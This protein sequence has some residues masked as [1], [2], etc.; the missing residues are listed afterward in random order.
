MALKDFDWK[1]LIAIGF[2]AGLIQV[3]FGV[4]MY[5]LGI[6]F[7][8][9]SI[10]ITLV[11]L[12]LCIVGGTRWYKASALQGK[13]TFRQACMVGI[14]ISVT[15]GIVYAVYN[16][17]SI[18][19]IYPHFLEDLISANLADAPASERTPEFIAVMRERVTANSIAIGNLIRLS[20]IG[21]IVSV[22]ASLILKREH[23][24]I[25]AVGR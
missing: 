15:T 22:L 20:V 2:V 23:T 12:L 18:S 24:L 13:I 14:V 6:Y 25:S 3:A 21:T 5:L 17:I 10:L 16:I 1:T 11:V 19:F 7:S 9:W 8:R 4:A